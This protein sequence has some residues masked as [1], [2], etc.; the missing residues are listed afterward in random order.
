MVHANGSLSETL[1]Y[2]RLHGLQGLIKIWPKPTS[3]A[4]KII[5]SYAAFEALLQIF[6]PGKRVE[7]PISPA[8]NKPVYKV[9]FM[10]YHLIDS[11]EWFI[12][13]GDWVISLV[14]FPLVPHKKKWCWPIIQLLSFQCSYIT[15][16][17]FVL[18]AGKWCSSI[19]SDIDYLPQPLV[20]QL[21]YLDR[22]LRHVMCNYPS[23]RWLSV[24]FRGL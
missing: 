20:V 14:F 6:L 17:Y 8:G 9:I 12:L 16:I 22:V 11:L 10:C 23:E 19:C 18:I 15:E 2:L 3:V 5:A 7:G 1:G 21:S 24:L 13:T 4:W